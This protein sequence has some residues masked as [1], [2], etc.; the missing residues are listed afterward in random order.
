MDSKTLCKDLS[1]VLM[2]RHALL[3]FQIDAEMAKSLDKHLFAD[4]E[5]KDVYDELSKTMNKDHLCFDK[6]F[7]W[8]RITLYYL[9]KRETGNRIQ[10]TDIISELSLLTYR[11]VNSVFLITPNTEK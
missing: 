4:E 8:P 11:Y 3:P 7:T 1:N 2:I 9:T 10:N 5:V 6:V